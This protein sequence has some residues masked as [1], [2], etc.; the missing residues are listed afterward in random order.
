MCVHDYKQAFHFNDEVACLLGRLLE[1]LAKDD[2]S[3][4]ICHFYNIYFAHSAGGRMIGVRLADQLLDRKKLAFYEY[5]G[6]ERG[7]KPL[8]EVCQSCDF[9]PSKPGMYC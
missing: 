5:E 4:F 9:W 8:L 2:P 1:K 7:D 6:G 3:A